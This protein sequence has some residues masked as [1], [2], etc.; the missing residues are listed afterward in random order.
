MLF[1]NSVG[2]LLYTYVSMENYP[3]GASLVRLNEYYKNVDNGIPS[4][5]SAEI[6]C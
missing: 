2:T 6:I 1:A 5:F 3:G 4:D